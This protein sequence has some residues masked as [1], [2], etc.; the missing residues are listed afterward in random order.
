MEDDLQEKL[1]DLP[2]PLQPWITKTLVFDLDETLV[3]CVDDIE[4]Q[5]PDVVL[6]VTFPTGETVN[7][8]IN[9]RP[10]AIECL[11]A[12]N[13][14]FQVVVFTASHYS[15]ADVV[16]DYLDP[17][18]ELIQYRLYRDSCVQTAEGVYIKD[19]RIFRNR[20]LKDIV[21][22]DNA[23]YSFGLQ[24][25]NG[26]PI[27]PFYDNPQDEELRHLVYYFNCLAAHVDIRM[28]NRLA[29]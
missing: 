21:I 29:F 8:G 20:D 17:K 5:N 7:A 18:R 16:L 19:L 9:V 14:Q 23:V 12:A 4:A 2:P 24:L 3:H 10:Y 11:R 13:E 28:Q 27:I 25:D 15:Y 6:S 1:V 22:V 26:V